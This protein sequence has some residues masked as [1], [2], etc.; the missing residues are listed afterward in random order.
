M[1]REF[2]ID[3]AGALRRV[4]RWPRRVRFPWGREHEEYNVVIKAE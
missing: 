1:I 2:G 3:V 4:P